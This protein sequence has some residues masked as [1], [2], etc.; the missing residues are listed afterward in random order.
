MEV[1]RFE[2]FLH[3]NN[4]NPLVEALKTCIKPNAARRSKHKAKMNIEI[5]QTPD[6]LKICPLFQNM[7]P[8][9]M[10]SALKH[11]LKHVRER[12]CKKRKSIWCIEQIIER[13]V[14]CKPTNH[15]MST[16]SSFALFRHNFSCIQ[17]SK[18]I[19]NID[20]LEQELP[21][22]QIGHKAHH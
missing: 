9:C 11:W 1:T 13:E 4:L 8:S 2:P 19:E 3:E 6:N 12:Y 21:D 20:T 7:L 17:V 10:H 14:V 5:G 15:K 18:C 22:S 16:K